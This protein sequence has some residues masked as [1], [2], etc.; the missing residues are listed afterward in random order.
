MTVEAAE[1]AGR[2]T[3]AA[4]VA[5]DHAAAFRLAAESNARHGKRLTNADKGKAVLIALKLFPG[6]SNAKIAE[7]CAVSD[8]TVENYRSQN[9]GPEPEIRT[10]ADGKKYKVSRTKRK[11]KP[12][13]AKVK[14]LEVEPLPVVTADPGEMLD[15]TIGAVSE[16]VAEVAEDER[17]N[18]YPPIGTPYGFIPHLRQ[19]AEE[20][21]HAIEAD[22]LELTAIHTEHKRVERK[23]L[24][25]IYDRFSMLCRISNSTRTSG[26]SVAA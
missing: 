15:C 2:E 18:D 3:I 1:L 26:S 19:A 22:C 5:P 8:Q 7:L 12:A 6:D 16:S 11:D 14:A 4:L 23:E 9:L 21:M 10:G 20:A 25:A 17:L 24:W 13:K